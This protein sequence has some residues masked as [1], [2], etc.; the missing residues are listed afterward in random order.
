MHA[1]GHMH[2]FGRIFAVWG[3]VSQILEEKPG[4]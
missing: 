1:L 4:F 3:L 2:A